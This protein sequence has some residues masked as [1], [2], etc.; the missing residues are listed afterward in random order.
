MLDQS[1]Q[2]VID[3]VKLP[4][5]LPEEGFIQHGTRQRLVDFWL[6][7]KALPSELRHL[8]DRDSTITNISPETFALPLKNG[9]YVFV[10][11]KG[12]YIVRLELSERF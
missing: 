8:V 10:R 11:L 1:L 9:S 3:E 12:T 2:K 6:M 4:I 7:I 5:E